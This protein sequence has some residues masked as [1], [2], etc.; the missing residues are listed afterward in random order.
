MY[1]TITTFHPEMMTRE[2]DSPA[3]S[4]ANRSRESSPS[5]GGR[6]DAEKTTAI[7]DDGA[8]GTLP[9]EEG[10]KGWLC[11]LGAF[12]TLFS[13]FGFLNAWVQY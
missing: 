12:L 11:V 3:E 2:S 7:V 10:V 1:R 5:G 6:E 4:L 9:P 13:S 8:K